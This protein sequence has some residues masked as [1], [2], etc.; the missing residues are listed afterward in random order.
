MLIDC[1]KYH[2]INYSS[3]CCY[4]H[5]ILMH[6]HSE[7]HMLINKFANLFL[8]TMNHHFKQ[9]RLEIESM[10]FDL[11]INILNIVTKINSHFYFISIV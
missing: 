4:K 9:N 1:K 8:K 10:S 5:L 2:G 6:D 7:T 11:L 3:S